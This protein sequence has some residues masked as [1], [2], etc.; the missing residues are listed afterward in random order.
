M[1]FRCLQAWRRRVRSREVCTA[2]QFGWLHLS[3]RWYE[4]RYGVVK[5]PEVPVRSGLISIMHPE[6]RPTHGPNYGYRSG[7]FAVLFS[8]L[9][10]DARAGYLPRPQR[11][12]WNLS[13][14][15][16]AYQVVPRCFIP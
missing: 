10:I 11:R 12:A 5:E 14:L 3:G 7:T 16:T 2:T 9:G 1:H 8:H 4:R 15:V 13:Q 6:A